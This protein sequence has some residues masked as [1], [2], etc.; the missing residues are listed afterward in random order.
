MSYIIHITSP[1]PGNLS[2]LLTTLL[3]PFISIL[4]FLGYAPN[5]HVR[6]PSRMRLPSGSRVA[7]KKSVRPITRRSWIDDARAICDQE[8]KSANSAVLS[9]KG[10]TRSLVPLAITARLMTL[11]LCMHMWVSAFL[12]VC[13]TTYCCSERCSWLALHALVEACHSRRSLPRW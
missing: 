5:E 6:Q 11:S 1:F 13:H 3:L 7:R 2:C 8:P 9:G 12:Q 4:H 10:G